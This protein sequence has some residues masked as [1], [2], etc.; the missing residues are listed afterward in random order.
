MFLWRM[1]S[2]PRHHSVAPV[3]DEQRNAVDGRHRNERH[4]VETMSDRVLSIKRRLPLGVFTNAPPRKEARYAAPM[5]WVKVPLGFAFTL[6]VGAVLLFSLEP[7]V[8][9]MLLPRFGGAP[10]VWTTCML[11]FQATLLL[12]YAYAH[13]MPAN[14]QPRRHARVHALV[15][16]VPLLVPP[17]AFSE[18]S[19]AS[20]SSANPVGSLLLLLCT[21]VGLPFFAVA[22]TTPLVQRW[23]FEAS[24]GRDPYF[25][26]V[27]SNVGSLVALAAYPLI[28]EPL[29][30]LRAQTHLWHAAYALFAILVASC[31]LVVWRTPSLPASIAPS[32]EEALPWPRVL[33]WLAL[34][35]VPASLLYGVT[36]Y[37]TTDIAPLPLLWVLPLGLYLLT[38]ALVFAR[39]PLLSHHAMVRLLPVAITLAAFVLL[40]EVARPAWL[41]V[42]VH[43]GMFFL[44]CMVC[45]GELA[46][47]R[48]SGEK[49]TAFYFFLSAGGVLGG[50]FNAL[51]APAIFSGLAE[52]PIAM[53]LVSLCLPGAGG[54][55]RRLYYAIPIGLSVLVAA[56]AFGGP[57]LPAQR[58]GLAVA[59]VCGVPLL[60]NYAQSHRP[61][62]FALGIAAVLALG[63]A[64]V[65]ALCPSLTR[66]RNLF[67][68]VKVTRDAHGKFVELTHG[69]TLHGRQSTDRE[70]RREA[71]GYYHP[72]GP[73]GSIFAAYDEDPAARAVGVIGLGAGTMA[74][75]ARAGSAWTFYELNPSIVRI[76]RDPRFFTYLADAFSEPR[77]PR[78]LTIVVGDARLRLREAANVGYGLLV[79]DAFS[80]DAIPVHLLTR[81]AFAL[82]FQKIAVHGMLALHVSNRYF[83][84]KPV[85]AALAR[86]AGLTAR[87]NDDMHLDAELLARGKS[88]SQ[89]L[90]LARDDADLRTLEKL[91][92]R[93]VPL[94]TDARR[95][96]SDDYSN[97]LSAL[98]VRR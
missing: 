17:I 45:H 53:V 49:L 87:S 19:V 39:K 74:S 59:V 7:M 84:L 93:W 98:S 15:V 83:D 47:D 11:F 41:V 26:Q 2:V 35:F 6:F 68:V 71:L 31:A 9:K 79:V 32:A 97:L 22:T 28:L 36:T 96:W 37:V 72:T 86:D 33:R 10:A 4:D 65:G 90:V 48:P 20:W 77:D 75:Y 56:L 38:F 73:L 78:A 89:W 80:S 88:P 23:F 92:A 60:L 29:L 67:G 42:L 70:R 57:V 62:R 44:S 13:A 46:Q 85:V 14:P 82:Y 12:G 34:A 18:V 50:A 76:A 40:A 43:L 61:L 54:S 27:A 66:D 69:N 58:A 24:A 21:Q 91:D 3:A 64:Y 95:P 81:E 52:Y 55:S 63:S 1:R 8:A 25:L 16:F 94:V 51:V 30:G 5:P